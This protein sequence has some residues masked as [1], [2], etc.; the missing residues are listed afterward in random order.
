MQNLRLMTLADIDAVHVIEQQVQ[1]HPW[2]RAL[3]IDSIESGHY[4][5]VLEQDNHVIGF[6]ILQQ[7]LDEANLLLMAIAPAFQQRGLGMQLLEQSIEGLGSACNMVF[8]EV[9]Q[10][11]TAAIALYEKTGFA[12]IDLRKNYYPTT[13]HGKEHAVLMALTLGSLFS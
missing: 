9:R 12:Q 4:C 13:T 10:S 7:V 2:S 8:L 1:T 6:C 11:N 5:T 3:L